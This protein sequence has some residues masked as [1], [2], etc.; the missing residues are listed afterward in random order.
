MPRG[1]QNAD[2]PLTS[3]FSLSDIDL[4]V[5]QLMSLDLKDAFLA[6]LSAYDTAHGDETQPD[7]TVHLAVATVEWIRI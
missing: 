1:K 7:Q 6:F 4:S 5:S 3:G 2:S